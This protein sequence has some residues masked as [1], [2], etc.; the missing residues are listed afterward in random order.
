MNQTMKRATLILLVLALS[1]GVLMSCNRDDGQTPDT[2]PAVT[3]SG[4]P[5]T[6]EEVTTE[7]VT[8][9]AVTTEAVTE[10]E[11]ETETEAV[12]EAPEPAYPTV[13]T[14]NGKDTLEIAPAADGAF[15]DPLTGQ[16]VEKAE[17][18]RRPVAIMLNNIATALPQ[19]HVDAADVLYECQ[20]EGGLTRLLG[21]Y[22]DWTELDAIG[23]VRSARE[24]YIDFAANHD[25]IFVHA[26]G[27][28]SAYVH[29]KSRKPNN[30]DAV[31]DGV[32]GQYFHR[33][34]ER[35]KTMSYEHTLVIDG[36][37]L[38][39]A[40]AKKKYRTEYASSFANPLH[41][42]GEEQVIDL[43]NGKSAKDITVKFGAHTAAFT[44]DKNSNTYLRFQNGNKHIEGTTDKQLAFE[45]VIVL[46]CPYTFTG[47]SK[48]HIEVDDLGTG[49][50][51]YI[52]GGEYVSINW[53][54]ANG[55][56]A[57]KLTYDSGREVYLTPGKTNIEIVNYDGNVTIQ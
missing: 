22:N 51:Y 54:K 29:L 18:E 5:E 37:N 2:T 34:P 39:A 47:D 42:V 26:G 49:K 14:D 10:T 48:N 46:F 43:A 30:L 52:T 4:E 19:Q 15:L 32:A 23:S 57:F 31:N 7:A 3:E 36:D 28:T 33:D 27:S 50:G 40:I 38:D 9:E 25:A 17:A 20:V 44:Y 11:T 45:N 53:S 8:T 35:R 24:Y 12:T 1:S 41:F 16:T 56:T 6:T 13:L 55:D 21:V